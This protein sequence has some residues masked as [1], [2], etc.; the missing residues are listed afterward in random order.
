MTI[1]LIGDSEP[2][3][4]LLGAWRQ[5]VSTLVDQ[6]IEDGVFE[7]LDRQHLKILDRVLLERR[8]RNV[9]QLTVFPC[10]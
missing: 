10:R 5:T 8:G 3:A 6:L 1:R 4:S 2:L 9:I 7:R